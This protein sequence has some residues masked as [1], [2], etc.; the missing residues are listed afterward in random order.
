LSPTGELKASGAVPQEST[1]AFVE[2]INQADLDGATNCFALDACLVTP[3]STAIRGR[4]EIRPILGAT[5]GRRGPPVMVAKAGGRMEAGDCG[6][7]G[8]GR[9]A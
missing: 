2:A 3:D 6:L 1:L 7:V 9:H 4:E 5:P 8:M